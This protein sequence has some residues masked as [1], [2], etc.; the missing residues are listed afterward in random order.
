MNIKKY[1]SY[2]L[3]IFAVAGTAFLA[4]CGDANGDGYTPMDDN[5]TDGGVVNDVVDDIEDNMTGGIRYREGRDV[6]NHI[7]KDAPD[8]ANMNI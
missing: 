6:E 5:A 7:T 2:T 1:A 4:S 8:F 3:A